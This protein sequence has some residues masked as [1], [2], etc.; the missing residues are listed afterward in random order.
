VK[1]IDFNKIRGIVS[2]ADLNQDVFQRLIFMILLGVSAVSATAVAIG[3]GHDFIV[4]ERL[5]IV[6]VVLVMWILAHVPMFLYNRTAQKPTILYNIYLYSA[7]GVL[8]LIFMNMK[9][10]PY[11]QIFSQI[12]Q[13]YALVFVGI[14]LLPH[15]QFIALATFVCGVTIVHH[16]LDYK[17]LLPPHGAGAATVSITNVIYLWLISVTVSGIINK[18]RLSM[19]EWREKLAKHN[20]MLAQ[21]VDAKAKI[22]KEQQE[23]LYQ[24]QKLHAIGELAGGI[25]HDYNNR[26]TVI[27]AAARKILEQH[28]DDAKVRE[29][30]SLMLSSAEKSANLT[31]Q[32]LT[33][34][35]KGSFDPAPADVHKLIGEAVAFVR[36]SI[37]KNVNIVLHLDAHSSVVTGNSG[38]IQN[39]ILNMALN[40]HDAMPGGGELTISTADIYLD[41]AVCRERSCEKGP[42]EYIAI[43][44]ADTS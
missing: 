40:A 19:M 6:E 21:E 3:L 22:I 9:A 20:E 34:A 36:L 28:P 25:A 17:E 32:L 7:F 16:I 12:P 38:Q 43:T 37:N 14:V 42:G 8:S 15:T 30:A 23:N 10:T 18:Y 27:I 35:R 13:S 26:L 31:S 2:T 33:F 4:P 1:L 24:S 39:A 41:E 29:Y 5:V 44:V 11:E